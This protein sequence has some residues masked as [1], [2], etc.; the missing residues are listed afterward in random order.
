L[1]LQQLIR[2]PNVSNEQ[3]NIR[4]CKTNFKK[5]KHMHKQNEIV[6]KQIEKANI[7]RKRNKLYSMNGHEL[8]NKRVPIVFTFIAR[9]YINSK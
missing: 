1:C 7:W 4:F 9:V 8:R 6:V 2:K 3:N 5:Q